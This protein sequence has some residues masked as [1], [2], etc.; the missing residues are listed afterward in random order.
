MTYYD[1]PK[2]LDAFVKKMGFVQA[3]W[4]TS[5][6]TEGKY[7]IRVFWDKEEWEIEVYHD[8]YIEPYTSYNFQLCSKSTNKTT[9]NFLEATLHNCLLENKT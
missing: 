2:A 8:E 9:D 5:N 7:V 1:M 4:R 3:S 6:Y